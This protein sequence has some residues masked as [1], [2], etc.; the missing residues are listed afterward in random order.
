MTRFLLDADIVIYASKG[1]PQIVAM[2][3]GPDGEASA[4]SA[5]V[6]SQLLQRPGLSPEERARIDDLAD[7]LPVIAFD[8]AASSSYGRLVEALGFSRPQAFDRMIAAHAISL[9]ATLVTNN[10]RHFANLPGLAIANWAEPT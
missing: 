2:L 5:L 1:H 8:R 10:T 7:Y 4:I 3:R 9:G 6:Y